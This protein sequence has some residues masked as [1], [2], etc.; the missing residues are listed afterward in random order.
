MRKLLWIIFGLWLCGL[1]ATAKAETYLL[2]DGTSLTGD[3]ISFNDDGIV[4]R[5][6]DDKYTDRILWT[7]FSQD[8]LKLLAKNPKLRPYA[9]PFIET[10][11]PPPP[12][13]RVQVHSVSRLALP[14]KQTVIG[15]LFS[16]FIGILLLL[17]I[18][19]ANVY[20][21]FEIAIFRA[22]PIGLV[23]GVAAVLPILGPIIFLS[24]STKVEGGATQ[25][26]MQMATG[27]PPGATA[28]PAT[29][30]Q[31]VAET[32]TPGTTET[33]HLAP[34]GKQAAASL[35]ETQVF[36]RGQF[37]FN[38]RFFETKFSGFFGM[39]RHGANKDMVLVVKTPRAQHI[40]ERISRIAANEA[41][42]EVVTGGSHHEV[43]VP[44]GE[45]QEIQLKHKDA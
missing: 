40:A 32:E 42:F 3:V 36:Q 10:P 37:T 38:R 30:G 8:A 22:R 11:P 29:A 28:P 15:A 44:F 20:A 39:T 25:E 7:K 45:I 9:E 16:S 17:L 33:V 27:A 4:F 14:P 18:Y 26:D 2:T 6:G 21:A 1:L 35:P 13:L 31:P 43:M 5:T 41:H 24:M 23:T 19:A 34:A 12:Q